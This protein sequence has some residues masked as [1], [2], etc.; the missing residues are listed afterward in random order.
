MK[1]ILEDYE[2]LFNF[3]ASKKL[4][5]FY[6]KLNLEYE[7]TTQQEKELIFEKINEVLNKEI[8]T[9]G[10]HRIN[11]WD[12]GWNENYVEFLRT[13]SE[14]SLVPKYFGKMK[15]NR[16]NNTFVKSNNPNFEYDCFSFL[17]SCLYE[18]YCK[19]FE[20]YYEFGCGTGHNL[21]RHEY[22]C[23]T[24]NIIGLDWSKSSQNCIDAINKVK[25][26]NYK[27][28]NFDFE[29]PN[30]EVKIENNSVICTLASLEQIGDRHENFINFLLENK[31]SICV[32]LEPIE[33]VLN[34]K[35]EMENLSIKYFKKR[36]Y[37]NGFLKKLKHLENDKKI[38]ILDVKKTKIGS[39]FIEGY[40]LIVWRVI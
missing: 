4:K 17:Q 38:E 27:S 25:E 10:P 9:S 22:F 23:E 5:S 32:H 21:L 24:K 8:K 11:D 39:Y 3:N 7:E 16:I 31:P 33:E 37:L 28:Y 2:K 15:F 19:N 34:D 14:E 26:K 13:G 40:T 20:N 12:S 35:D 18:A 30:K 6:D 36:K 29:N 1:I